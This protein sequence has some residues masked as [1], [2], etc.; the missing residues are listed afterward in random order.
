VRSK[1]TSWGP[2]R[3]D[4]SRH[5]H[6]TEHGAE[7]DLLRLWGRVVSPGGPRAPQQRHGPGS[8]GERSSGGRGAAR[9]AGPP[10]T[11]V[12]Q[13]PFQSA[14]HADRHNYTDDRGVRED[15][16]IWSL[17]YCTTVHEKLPSAYD[18]SSEPSTVGPY[19]AVAAPPIIAV[20]GRFFVLGRQSY[21]SR[22]V[23]RLGRNHAARCR[24]RE[25]VFARHAPDST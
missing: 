21:D 5:E 10:A 11:V 14:A 22:K 12:T 6:R 9:G 19:P 4:D 8:Q 23:A 3:T 20:A 16:T 13:R 1:V 25:E 17:C 18:V 24:L 7:D 2:P 15:L